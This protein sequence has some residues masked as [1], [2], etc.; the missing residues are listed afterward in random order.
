MRYYLSKM[1]SYL[2]NMLEEKNEKIDLLSSYVLRSKD[3][4]LKSKE[5][6]MIGYTT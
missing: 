2:W 4:S 1:D 3:A 6:L 5:V